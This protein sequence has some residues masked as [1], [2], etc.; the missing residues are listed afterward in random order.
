MHQNENS[1]D[2]NSDG[3]RIFGWDEEEHEGIE[4]D[5]EEDSSSDEEESDEKL[6]DCFTRYNPDVY[7]NPVNVG[8]A[9]ATTLHIFAGGDD[10]YPDNYILYGCTYNRKTRK[11]FIAYMH[12]HDEN[13]GGCDL[14]R[15]GIPS[16]F[17][18]LIL[19][20]C[21]I[22]TFTVEVILA[23]TSLTKIEVRK[24]GKLDDFMEE[25][26]FGMLEE[27]VQNGR[28]LVVMFDGECILGGDA[29]G[30]KVK[31]KTEEEEDEEEVN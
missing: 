14:L 17:T 8:G 31:S 5:E 15:Y 13:G 11:A 9:E 29:A 4:S 6:C 16:H 26:E 3:G 24:N 25:D 21:S 1:D 18:T 12:Y 27:A 19:E 10:N 23:C 22:D 2:D 28:N 20:C 7:Y 30:V